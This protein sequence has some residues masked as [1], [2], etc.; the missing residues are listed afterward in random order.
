[1]NGM[2]GLLWEFGIPLFVLGPFL[3][4]P[5][6]QRPS[7]PPVPLTPGQRRLRRWVLIVAAALLVLDLAPG[8]ARVALV[9]AA[10]VV[11]GLVIWGLRRAR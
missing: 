6:A 1:M 3:A 11:T 5:R 2:G 8:W 9:V 4:V 10:A 7:P